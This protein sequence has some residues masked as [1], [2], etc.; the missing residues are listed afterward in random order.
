MVIWPFFCFFHICCC[1][2]IYVFISITVDSQTL[3]LL[4]R[5]GPN[6]CNPWVGRSY[7]LAAH[8]RCVCLEVGGAGAPPSLPQ[9][10]RVSGPTH[11]GFLGSFPHFPHCQT[12]QQVILLETD[13]GVAGLEPCLF[14]RLVSQPQL[15]PIHT[16]WSKASTS[17]PGRGA[18]QPPPLTPS[19]PPTL[20]C[21]L[22]WSHCPHVG[23]RRSQAFRQFQLLPAWGAGN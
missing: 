15:C 9:A 23:H 19:P 16:S 5:L 21:R 7:L 12:P 20:A 11:L 17:I 8:R 6:T 1:L 18:P 13:L 4:H 14:L 2:S 22:L 10:G 3:T